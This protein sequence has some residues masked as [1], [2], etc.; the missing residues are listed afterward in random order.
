M[1]VKSL[2]SVEP[3]YDAFLGELGLTRKRFSHVDASGDWLDVSDERP[4]NVAEYYEEAKP[5]TVAFFIGIIEDEQMQPVKTRIAFRVSRS[6]LDRLHR[7]LHELG[8]KRIEW[9]EDMEQYPA[10]FFEDPGGTNLEV[11]ARHI[12][13]DGY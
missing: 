2:P 13:P 11:C 10:L 4:Y 5:G 7:R 3:F 8:A 6:E 1:R 12:P 9:S